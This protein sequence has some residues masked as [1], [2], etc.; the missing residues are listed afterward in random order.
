M[1]AIHLAVFQPLKT[2][3][4]INVENFQEVSKVEEKNEDETV[5]SIRDPEE[6]S[7]KWTSTTKLNTK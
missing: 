7:C 6:A 5:K 4:I 3:E 1:P 2:T